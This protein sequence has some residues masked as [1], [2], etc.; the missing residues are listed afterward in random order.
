MSVRVESSTYVM[1]APGCSGSGV[2]EPRSGIWVSGGRVND[3][4]LSEVA[5][6][7][8]PELVSGIGVQG[9][10]SGKGDQRWCIANQVELKAQ[11]VCSSVFIYMRSESL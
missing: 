1:A 5:L 7:V 4:D 3:S 11:P 6:G 10:L 9:G 8:N 2:L